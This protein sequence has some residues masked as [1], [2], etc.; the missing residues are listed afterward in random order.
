MLKKKCFFTYR[1]YYSVAFTAPLDLDLVKSSIKRLHIPFY[2][3]PLHD[4]EDCPPHYHLLIASDFELD[5]KLDYWARVKN[6][7][8]FVDYC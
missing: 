1:F 5:L 2:I 4:Y 8:S 3:S 7:Y 6:A